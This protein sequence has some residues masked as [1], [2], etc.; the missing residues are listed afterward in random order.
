MKHLPLRQRV[1][2]LCVCKA[3]NHILWDSVAAEM[4]E[5]QKGPWLLMAQYCKETGWELLAYKNTGALAQPCLLPSGHDAFGACVGGTKSVTNGLLMGCRCHSEDLFWDLDMPRLASSGGLMC[6]LLT[7]D[8]DHV[9][10]NVVVFNCLTGFVKTLPPPLRSDLLFSGRD[11]YNDTG[12][13]PCPC[14]TY[15]AVDDLDSKRYYIMLTHVREYC[16]CYLST[17]DRHMEVFDSKIGSWTDVTIPGKFEVSVDAYSRHVWDGNFFFIYKRTN[18]NVRLQVNVYLAAYSVVHDK[19]SMQPLPVDCSRDIESF[20]IHKFEG[21]IFL[22]IHS[23]EL[24]GFRIWEVRQTSRAAMWVEIA[25]T[26]PQIS[27]DIKNRTKDYKNGFQ[28][29]LLAGGSCFY[30]IV[31]VDGF[32]V[33]EIPPLVFDMSNNSWYFLPAKEWCSNFYGILV[34]QPSLSARI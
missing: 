22:A 5:M 34:H 10:G 23:R 11:L 24:H 18:F 27:S 29:G 16:E 19:W 21:R 30:F 17:N 13:L 14:H 15:M 33:R 20:F 6:G 4:E 2:A 25:C 31:Y 32:S 7:A 8:A 12:Y 28:S 26:P 9:N 3:W 1:Q